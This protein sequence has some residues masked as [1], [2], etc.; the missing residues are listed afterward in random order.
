MGL[1][2]SKHWDSV[3]GVLGLGGDQGPTART[4]GPRK[5]RRKLFSDAGPAEHQDI[6]E[7]NPGPAWETTAERAPEW[8]WAWTHNYRTVPEGGGQTL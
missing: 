2:S 8:R 4:A 5:V 6:A 3:D 1:G 7:L